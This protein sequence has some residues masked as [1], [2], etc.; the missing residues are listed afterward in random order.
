MPRFFVRSTT[1]VTLSC[2]HRARPARIASTSARDRAE[3]STETTENDSARSVGAR[4]RPK[5]WTA[6]RRCGRR[7]TQRANAA[8]YGE[9]EV[10]DIPFEE[11]FCIGIFGSGIRGLDDPLF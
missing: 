10:G 11:D 9:R 4:S 7:R 3:R 1:F 6:R 2:C 8:E 5:P